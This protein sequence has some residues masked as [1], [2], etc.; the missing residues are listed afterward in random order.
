MEARAF[1]HRLKATSPEY[2]LHARVQVR[3]FLVS[4]KVKTLNFLEEGLGQG[5]TEVAFV[6]YNNKESCA[7]AFYLNKNQLL[8]EGLQLHFSSKAM[9]DKRLA[10]RHSHRQRKQDRKI[11]AARL[12]FAA[13]G[14]PPPLQPTEPS[15]AAAST[16]STIAVATLT[17][18]TNA[19]ATPTHSTN[20]AATPR[21]STPAVC[22]SGGRRTLDLNRL[23]QD[24]GYPAVQEAEKPSRR[25]R[26]LLIDR[27]HR[28]PFTRQRASRNIS[29][30]VE[31]SMVAQGKFEPTYRRETGARRRPADTDTADS[32]TADSEAAG[33]DGTGLF[34]DVKSHTEDVNKRAF[35]HQPR[36]D[37]E[38]RTEEA[39]HEVCSSLRK[40]ALLDI[41]K[42]FLPS[43]RQVLPNLLRL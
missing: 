40:P 8:V 21:Q 15:A 13:P 28:A 11:A 6:E 43:E 23:R 17:H 14:Q 24:L 39:T 5:A 30:R 10:Q 35:P 2:A 36:H 7:E 22:I 4:Q 1:D 33:V 34:A 26:E 16:Q 41:F 32:D 38:L 27:S 20:A 12:H 3:R 37:S 29:G 9:M 25:A 31:T 18:F 19:A 42:H